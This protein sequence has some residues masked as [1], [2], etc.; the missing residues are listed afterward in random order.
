[1]IDRGFRGDHA[2]AEFALQ[3]TDIIGL[4][5]ALQLITHVGQDGFGVFNPKWLPGFGL[6]PILAALR[7]QLEA[8]KLGDA[9]RGDLR[10]WYWC[11]VF[12]ERYSSAVESKSR[13]DYAEMTAYWFSGASEPTVF[14]EARDWIGAP[15]FRIRNS[16]SYASAVYSGVFCLLGLRGARDWRRREAIQL[17]ELQDHHIFPQAYLKRHGVS[18]KADLNTIANRTLI[19]DETNGKIKDKSPA[20]YIQDSDIFP[21]GPTN[22]LLEPH[23]INAEIRTMM[24][25]A[26]EPLPNEQ[27]ALLYERFIRARE[28]AIIHEIRHVCGIQLVESTVEVEAELEDEAA[29][30][31]L[32]TESSLE[33]E[34]ADLLA[35]SDRT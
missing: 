23:F 18:K 30:D 12:M 2:W 33:D 11:N 7:S 35:E 19:S 9:A 28:Q 10:R 24:N 20:T 21:A 32:E 31:V 1:M 27:L 13:K 8:N 14:A 15:G 4:E 29:P 22:D 17:Q 3:L 25:Q 34:L 5:R 16:A 6:V 26:D